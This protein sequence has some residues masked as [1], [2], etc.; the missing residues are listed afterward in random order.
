MGYLL[1][2]LFA[3]SSKLF[4]GD[5]SS[6]IKQLF[7]SRIFSWK[8]LA[9]LD[10]PVGSFGTVQNTVSVSFQNNNNDLE[11]KTFYNRTTNSLILSNA[12]VVNGK[13]EKD[14]SQYHLPV[15]SPKQ[16]LRSASTTKQFHQPPL[17]HARCS[18]C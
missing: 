7:L 16:F 14:M 17:L 3:N 6:T 12:G 4:T 11:S 1:G 15:T 10:L 5:I 13:I 2:G 9:T 18:K 8:Q